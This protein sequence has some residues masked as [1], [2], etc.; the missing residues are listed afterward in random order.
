MSYRVP[1]MAEIN[2]KSAK[3]N[4]RTLVS[5]FSGCGGSCLG[6]RMSGFKVLWANEF[7]PEAR[8]TYEANHRGV[9]VDPRDI[10][11]ISP[12]DIPGDV[13]VLEGSPPCAAFSMAGAGP[14][15]WGKVRKYSDTEQRV[16]DLF[17]E[18]IRI[19]KGVQPKV[20]IAENVYGLVRG[21]AKGWFKQIL[22]AMKLAGYNVEVVILESEWLGVPQSRKRVIFQG[23][24][25]DLYKKGARHRWPTA[26][27]SVVSI[28]ESF[29]DVPKPACEEERGISILGTTLEGEWRKLVPGDASP[30]YYSL[31]RCSW[32]EPCPAITASGGQSPSAAAVT[33]PSIPRKFSIPELRRLCSFPDDFVLTGTYAQR[34]ERLGRSVPPLMMKAV[35]EEVLKVLEAVS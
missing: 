27:K 3:K 20:F 17:F 35:A 15:G 11:L 1:L 4:G 19:L 31:K 14:D 30:R 13:D 16:D 33:H 18:F 8:A 29:E 5:T 24:R 34:Y 28:R 7:V 10:R 23:I 22:A 6:F 25:N 12:G 2:G 21:F 9:K 32:D 26:L